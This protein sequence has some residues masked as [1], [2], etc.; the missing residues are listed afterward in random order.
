MYIC[1]HTYLQ[2]MEILTVCKLQTAEMYHLPSRR[3]EFDLQKYVEPPAY[4]YQITLRRRVKTASQLFLIRFFL[5][6][7]VFVFLLHCS[8]I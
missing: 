4:D 1:N 8:V 7:P 3:G 5:K 6:L 2:N